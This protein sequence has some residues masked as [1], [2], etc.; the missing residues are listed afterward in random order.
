[1]ARIAER[2]VEALSEAEAAEEL[3]RLAAEIAGHDRRY[4][5]NDA[6]TI[7]DAAYD[8]LRRRNG[9]IERRFPGLVREDSPSIRVG[10]APSAKFAKVTHAIPMLSLDNAFSDDDVEDFAKRVRRF[11]KLA[12]D[13]P[14][15]ITAEP[16]IDGLSLSLRYEDGR[17]VSAATRGDGTVGE[18][19]TANA[20][21]IEDIPHR[22]SGIRPA[23]F[24]VRGEVYM[25]HADF[26]ALNE[27]LAAGV[28][29][30]VAE[31]A[32][33]EVDAIAPAE[34]PGLAEPEG[35]ADDDAETAKIRQ[36]ANPRNAA[37]GSLRQKD[38]GVTRSRP[39]KFF[40]YAWGEVSEVPGDTQTEVVAALG[41]MGF[42]V[43][44]LMRRF[45]TIE[46]LIAHYHAIEEKRADLGYD[47]DG[48]VYKVDD[49]GL[50][51]RL[52]FV[53]RSPRWAIA[54]KFPAEQATTLLQDIDIQVGR[55]GALTPV[56]K[57]KPVTVGGVVV[58]NATLHNEDY[59]AGKDS[60]GAPI[61]EGRDIRIGD[62]VLI[63]RAGDVIPQVLDVVLEK[64]PKDADPYVFPDHC[65]VCGSKAVREV[66][67]RTGRPDSK[68]RCTAGLTCPA[69]G[70]EGLKHFVSRGAFDIEGFGETY[71]ETLFDAG[72]VRQPADI[73]SLTFEPL[74]EAI[75]A[76]RREVSEARRRSQGMAEPEKPAKK[77][78]TSKAIDNLLAA[79]DA[80][81][82]VA[83]NRFIFGLGI[84]H[85][86]E[87][88]A[89][90]LA[91]HFDDVADLLAGIDRAAAEQPG[92]AWHRLKETPFVGESSFEALLAVG[93]ERLDDAAYDPFRDPATG[94][95][96]NQRAALKER[97]GD[98]AGLCE[99][100]RAARAE[101]PGP[102]YD[103]LKS[104][105]DIGEVATASLIEFFGE[106]HNRE[107]VEALVEAG[108]TTTNDRPTAAETASSPVAGKTVVFTGSLEKMTR[109]EA[110]AMAEA[111]GAKVAG[112][113]SKK[114][115]LVVAGPGAGSKL[116]KA[117]EFGVE[118]IDEDGWF[119]L[120]GRQ[121]G[122][123]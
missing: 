12:D 13:A 16:K 94:L 123:G 43:N 77:A 87:T 52:G 37:A 115:D 76:R 117:T 96:A 3:K 54:H 68:R 118:V 91:R 35:E 28:E 88:S 25:S 89:K 105:R 4:H 109:D 10:A 111:L 90:A 65:P 41:R 36:F 18:D 70:R 49:L 40:A 58:S 56:A 59:I 100:I 97:F 106:A 27:R 8:A 21:T 66:N 23:V 121:P 103:R 33:E 122:E 30:A 5:E 85:I 93:D 113:V 51:K 107:A 98:A 101:A 84:R 48:V 22:L 75:E 73:F 46:G 7:S 53:S 57:L 120:I 79:I 110:K 47:I 80:R 2:P 108:V 72:L 20:L 86:G 45:D 104:D 78:E 9:A 102:L 39:L 24:E 71:I 6:P 61:R 31:A 92:A 83:L 62:T 114:T 95:K 63:Q 99:A 11:L 26:A 19:V 112:S 69:Q 55:T 74:R 82:T 50:Q 1:M 29:P 38:A 32:E 34:S 15:A 17:L 67:P 64:R 44:P 14:L 116:A 60:D 119:A 42:S 81:R